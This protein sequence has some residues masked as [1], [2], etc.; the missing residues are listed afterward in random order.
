MADLVGQLVSNYRV[1]RL[2][3]EGGFAQ[4]YLGEHVDL[5]TRAAI[6]VLSTQISAAEVEQFRLE[7]RTIAQLRH[8]HIVKVFDFGVEASL[9]YLIMEYAPGG[10]LRQH[11]P[12]GAPLAPAHILPYVR[13]VA[14]AL[15]H[16]HDHK[17]IHRDMKPENILLGE[18]GEVLLSDFGVAVL[19]LSSRLQNAQEVAGTAAYMAPEQINA[20]AEYASDQYALGV[21]IYEWLAG[22]RPF[23]GSLI[24]L[25]AQ[26]LYAPPPSLREKAPMLSPTL[27]RVVLTTLEKDPRARFGSMR[28]FANAFEQACQEPVPPLTPSEGGAAATLPLLLRPDQPASSP[29]VAPMQQTPAPPLPPSCSDST[30]FSQPTRISA[31]ALEDGAASTEPETP[32]PATVTP[33]TSRPPEHPLA[34]GV[35]EPRLRLARRTVLVAAAGLGVLAATGS[36]AA[37]LG[38]NHRAQ[39]G[40][41]VAR[42]TATPTLFPTPTTQLAPSATPVPQPITITQPLFAYHGHTRGLDLLAWLPDLAALRLA[43]GSL[44][45]LQVWDAL[46]GAHAAVFRT[47]WITGVAWSPDGKKLASNAL[48]GGQVQVADAASGAILVSSP[49]PAHS[50]AWSPDGQRL[51]SEVDPSFVEVWPWQSSTPALWRGHTAGVANTAWS[52]NGKYLASGSYDATAIVWD[53]SSGTPLKTLALPF[54]VVVAL[55]WSPDSTRL[56]T[57]YPKVSAVIWEVLTGQQMYTYRGYSNGIRGLAWSPDGKRI[58]ACSYDGT[59]Q[60]WDAATGETLVTYTGHL[61]GVGC[62]AWSPDGNYIATGSDD[63]TVHVWQPG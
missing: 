6:K 33:A 55:A 54:G 36:A 41:A 29:S 18:R 44:E 48:T 16:A 28:A 15:Q 19:A 37:W 10:T 38:L 11:L 60:V 57:G 4:V 35:E 39:A 53:A 22:E 61:S 50:L 52:P 1:M 27:E 24:E 51:A 3:G 40:A 49:L 56:V 5:G 14:G 43:S 23:Q 17:L 25:Y 46:T 62:I 63:T 34:P 21:M 20:Q 31:P 30:S 8:R 47:G 12:T 13:Q 42:A 26:Q 7:A 58:A 45:S 32:Q 2:L 59:A 9:P